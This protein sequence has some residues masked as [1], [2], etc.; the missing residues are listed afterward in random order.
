M[1]ALGC[2]VS[3]DPA[4]D[5]DTDATADPTLSTSSA[6]PSTTGQRWE[7]TLGCELWLEC[8]DPDEREALLPEYG[9]TGTCWQGKARLVEEC[10]A[11]CNAGR[12]ADCDPTMDSD[13]GPGPDVPADVEECALQTLAPGAVSWV[14]TGDGADVLPT[15]IGEILERNCSCHVTELEEFGPLTPL[16][17]GALRF[18]THAEFHAT[19]QG[20]PAFV[21][22]DER[23]FDTLSMPPLYYCGDG[24]YGSSVHSPDFEIFAAWLEAEAPDAALWAELRPD[25]LP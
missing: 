9:P 22:V 13:S 5:T 21:L 20:S 18:T 1:V 3:D 14:V 11:M 16:Y 2:S 25:D 17:E 8:L 24:D 15:E 4:A 19:W 7:Q 6:G 12:D 23:T 10:D